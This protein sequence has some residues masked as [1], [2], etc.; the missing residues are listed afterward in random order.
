MVT[1]IHIEIDALF[2]LILCVIA[3]QSARNVSSRQMSRVLFRYTVYGIMFALALDILWMLIDGRIFPGA[4]FLNRLVNA[5]FLPSGVLL[6]C[7]WYLYV[8]E[9]LGF[10]LTP[11][12]CFVVFLPGLIMTLL[13]LLSIR[14][15]WVFSVDENNV[16]SRGSLFPLQ[17]AA[18]VG[19]LLISLLHLLSRLI[20]GDRNPYVR[21]LLLFYI[22]PV[23]GTFLTLP[24]AGMPGTWTCAAAAIILMYIDDQDKEITRDSLTGL[25]NRKAL[26]KAFPEYMRQLTPGTSL[27]LFAMDLDHFKS[28]N[29]TWGHPEGDK[30]LITAARL[31]LQAVGNVRSVVARIGGDEFVIL[32]FLPGPE[33][34]ALLKVKIKTAFDIHTQDSRCPYPLRVSVGYAACEPGQTLEQVLIEADRELYKDKRRIST[35]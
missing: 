28:I 27:Y 26:S 15:G 10:E 23:A 25:N 30:A 20:K 11:R 35:G 19:M 4:F 5:I 1:A 14:T 8:L 34:A 21:K 12:L 7:I 9:S 22:V 3:L 29:D 2:F 16:Y 33:E 31:F 6:A 32:G 17:I 13:N 18:A 24:H